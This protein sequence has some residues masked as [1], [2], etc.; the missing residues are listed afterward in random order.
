MLSR[1]SSYVA[2]YH[3]SYFK[4][5]QYQKGAVAC[6][7]AHCNVNSRC[8]PRLALLE[9]HVHI[10][11]SS[12]LLALYLKWKKSF[13]VTDLLYREHFSHVAVLIAQMFISHETTLMSLYR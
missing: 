12:S 13:P 4:P 8:I 2:S 7:P 6:C 3:Y 10:V 5:P 1:L 9:E 11:R